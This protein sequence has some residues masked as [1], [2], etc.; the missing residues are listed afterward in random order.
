[1]EVPYRQKRPIPVILS[2]SGSYPQDYAISITGSFKK[3]KVRG[4]PIY[5]GKEHYEQD[6]KIQYDPAVILGE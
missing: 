6:H 5:F 3:V 4:L 2:A 1:M